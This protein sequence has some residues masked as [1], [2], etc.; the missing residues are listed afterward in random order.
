M[1]C[2]GSTKE[3][4]ELPRK[5]Y[6]FCSE[7]QSFEGRLLKGMAQYILKQKTGKLRQT[8]FSIYKKRRLTWF[9]LMLW[10]LQSLFAEPYHG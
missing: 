8:L 3:A 6:R 5:V 1:R 4:S 2:K 10:T 7:T 9:K